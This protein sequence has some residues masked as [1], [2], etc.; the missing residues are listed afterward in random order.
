MSDKIVQYHDILN[1]LLNE[2]NFKHL[3]QS[4]TPNLEMTRL[5]A[6]NF[7]QLDNPEF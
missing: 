3:L 5:L 7:P 6:E 1:Y 2:L 4:I